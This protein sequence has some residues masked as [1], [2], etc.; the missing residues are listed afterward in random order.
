MFI[1]RYKHLVPSGR[2]IANRLVALTVTL[3]FIATLVPVAIASASKSSTMPC[4]VGKE[5]GHCESEIPAQKIS[6]PE[7]EPMCGLDNAAA[8]DDGI[9]IVAE[10]PRN[11]SHHSHSQNAE[12]GLSN[13]ESSSSSAAESVTLSQP[14]HTDC[15]ACVSG[16]ARNLRERAT[17]H[18]NFRQGSTS[19]NLSRFE[20]S[21]P[22]SFSNGTWEQTI[23]R[24]PPIA[25]L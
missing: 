1:A 14:C 17:P 23:P 11:E 10:S 19:R 22:F 16:L 4:C 5:A 6:L 8:E 15:C 13:A 9:T 20:V 24:G 2:V 7:P 3:S 21:A 12:V 18:A 25:L